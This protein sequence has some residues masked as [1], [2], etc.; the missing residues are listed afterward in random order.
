MRRE[1]IGFT[2]RSVVKFDRVACESDTQICQELALIRKE[3]PRR[4]G[5]FH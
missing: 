3:E 4:E 5:L 1:R 2:Q